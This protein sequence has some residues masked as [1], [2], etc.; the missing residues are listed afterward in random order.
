MTVEKVLIDALAAKLVLSPESFDVIVASNLFGDILSDLAAAIA[1]SIGV[2]PSGN[3]NP[4]GLH[5]SMFEPVHG[6]APDIAGQNIANPVGQLWA[7]AMMLEHLGEKAAADEL[8]AAF[9]ACLGE[10]IRTRDLGGT[11]TT[12]EFSDAVNARISA[13]V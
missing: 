1:G 11:A 12:T 10:G 6:S 8:V 7:G 4:E 2:A 9:E 5:P 3:L 13:L